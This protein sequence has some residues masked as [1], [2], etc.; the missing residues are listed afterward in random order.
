MSSSKKTPESSNSSNSNTKKDNKPI[1][2]TPS[3]RAQSS[4][5]SQTKS[6]PIPPQVSSTP[7][8]NTIKSADN[9]KKNPTVKETTHPFKKIAYIFILL[10]IIIAG[11]FIYYEGYNIFQSNNPFQI[12]PSASTNSQNQA[13]AEQQLE[14]S[15]LIAHLEKKTK[16]LETQ[17]QHKSNNQKQ[18][19]NRLS[20]L[21][22][23]IDKHQQHQQQQIKTLTNQVTQFEVLIN[24]WKRRLADADLL[25]DNIY[26]HLS[27]I[28]SQMVLNYSPQLLA[29]QLATVDK[30]VEELHIEELSVLRVEL[31]NLMKKLDFKQSIPID[32]WLR[33]IE[34]AEKLIPLWIKQNNNAKESSQE[35][36][37]VKNI[38]TIAL[39]ENGNETH[40]DTLEEQKS[41]WETFTTFFLDRIKNAISLSKTEPSSS[42]NNTTLSPPVFTNQQI[43]NHLKNRFELMRLSI[44][45]RDWD[46]LR[47]QSLEMNTWLME[48]LPQGQQSIAKQLAIMSQYKP[49]YINQSLSKAIMIITNYRTKIEPISFQPE[50]PAQPIQE[51]IVKPTPSSTITK[52]VPIPST[53]NITSTPINTL[54][55]LPKQLT[56]QTQTTTST[57]TP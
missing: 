47:E 44:L 35:N 42:A 9:I 50:K 10:L 43:S 37:T 45:S 22:E 54:N 24:R 16:N 38:D 11:I 18:Q 25:I 52:I 17:I 56:T 36:I 21:I 55:T 57:L 12:T 41:F 31:Q 30:L 48:N 14:Y 39:S 4:S 26:N 20:S 34:L 2:T 46:S 13:L 33:E 3:T 51:K 27:L 32:S 40:S 53:L 7:I 5:T 28:Q 6:A 15:K 49:K 8:T 29:Q 23:L 19:D 1:H